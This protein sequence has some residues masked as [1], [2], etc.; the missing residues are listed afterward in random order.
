MVRLV[1][2]PALHER[3]S[4]DSLMQLHSPISGEEVII[5]IRVINH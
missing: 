1:P 2:G 3:V 4:L 5:L